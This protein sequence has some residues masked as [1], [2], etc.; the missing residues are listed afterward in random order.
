LTWDCTDISQEL[1]SALI[2]E[3]ANEKQP[4]DGEIYRKIR[5]YQREHNA[6]FEKR[7]WARLSE[8]KARRLRQLSNDIDLRSAFDG[9]LAIPGLWGGMSLG[10]IGKMMA[11]KCDEVVSSS[12]LCGRG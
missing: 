6:A 10:N 8:D 2:D 1:R 7:W 3:Y 4:S 9:L 12:M 5:Q 11:L